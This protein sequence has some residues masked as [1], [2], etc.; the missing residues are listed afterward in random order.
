MCSSDL[1]IMV[2]G[3][4]CGMIARILGTRGE[5]TDRITGMGRTKLLRLIR[6]SQML[7]IASVRRTMVLLGAGTKMEISS[8]VM[9]RSLGRIGQDTL[10]R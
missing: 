2:P 5:M 8:G 10:S 7:A 4:P 9:R 6:I 1:S 3:H